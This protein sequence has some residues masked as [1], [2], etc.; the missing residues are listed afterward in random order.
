[1]LD[2]TAIAELP[3]EPFLTWCKATDDENHLADDVY[4]GMR[5]DP[6]LFLV[7]PFDD[8]ATPRENLAPDWE[9]LFESTLDS[10][11]TDES[12]WPSPRSLG[13]FLEW[14]KVRVFSILEDLVE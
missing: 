11:S 8:E 3:R 6:T 10:W 14:C 4:E 2:R 5:S 12:H 1:M 9:E 13:L 7:A